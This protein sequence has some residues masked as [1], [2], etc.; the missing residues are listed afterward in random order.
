V[1][2]YPE[3][4]SGN[5][6]RAVEDGWPL[7]RAALP[8]ARHFASKPGMCRLGRHARTASDEPVTAIRVGRSWI[9]HRAVP[10]GLDAIGQH[11]GG[12]T[13]GLRRH[14]ACDDRVLALH[15]R[16]EALL[17]DH[18]RVVVGLVPTLVS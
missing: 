7:G 13:L 18:V 14:S 5:P 6:W 3:I 2:E 8:P 11:L 9:G 12:C 10:I 15:Q 17:R 16:V 1:D 4:T